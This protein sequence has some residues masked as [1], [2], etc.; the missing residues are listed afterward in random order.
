MV[1][2][3]VEKIY[4]KYKSNL[5]EIRHIEKTIFAESYDYQK[6][7]ALL[8]EKSYVLREIYE[9]N[10]KL[11][12]EELRELRKNEEKINGELVT[13][14]LQHIMYFVYEDHQD[15]ELTEK[16]LNWLEPY[17]ETKA[18]DWQKIKFYYIK[19]LMIAKGM[20]SHVQ[21]DWYEKITGVCGD[22]TK[23]DRNGSKERLLDSYLYRVMYIGAY[24][25]EKT[26]L[27]FESVDE[28]VRQWKRPETLSLLQ[29][30]YGKEK[31]VEHYINMRLELIEYMQYMIVTKEN[32]ACMSKEKLETLYE[33]F[34]KNYKIGVETRKL[35]CRIFITYHK[36]RYFM[37]ITDESEY[38]EALDMYRKPSP[39]E[40]PT[41]MNFEMYRADLFSC[42]ECNRYFCNSF[43]YALILSPEKLKY[44]KEQAKRDQIY[45]EIEQYVCGLSTMENGVYM[46]IQL[47]E[48]MK[49]LA[50]TM[51]EN[52]VF[53]L[54]ETIML[55]RQLPTAIHLAMVSKLVNIYIELILNEKPE[56]LIGLLGT[57]SVGEVQDKREEIISFAVKA[58]LC[59]DIGKLI[60]TDIINLQSRR[61]TDEEF[62]MIKW[63]PL[64]G[65]SIAEEI[66]AFAP[67]VDI[68][69]GHHLFADQTGGYPR[70]VDMSQSAD[71]VIINLITI[72]DSIDAAT[73]ILGR[74]YAKGK[75]FSKILAE[76]KEQSGTRYSKELVE[77][78][79]NSESLKIEMTSLTGEKRAGVYHDLYARRVKPLALDKK[80][81]ER[82]FRTCGAEDKESVVKFIN[83]H[84]KIDNE[85]CINKYDSCE[86]KYLVK[87]IEDDIIGVFFGKKDTLQG[88]D[89]VFIELLLVNEASRHAGIGRRLL[90][91][92]EEE[93]REKG[94]MYV[95]YNIHNELGNMERFMWIN[96]YKSGKDMI[97]K[98]QINNEGEK[99]GD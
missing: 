35:N 27:F 10:E 45:E 24:Q 31:D 52:K 47:V 17:I 72:C 77:V 48:I 90:F 65:K 95:A 38:V 70:E 76:L 99:K 59:H 34:E 63:H 68:I 49:I 57:T 55:H 60:S 91:Y 32:I 2:T 26:D 75:D 37:G 66:P 11:L 82:Y 6:W 43:S 41:D 5:Y 1:A 80:Y 71:K 16:V 92:V 18:Q 89:A 12:N 7:E 19:G 54:L 22:W 87:N 40:Y 9:Q 33:Y 58:G 78:L 29:E 20:S 25:R 15:F 56:L 94:Y 93:L 14:L 98:K 44:A 61:I 96:G 36:L 67:Y 81:V 88:K 4:N 97:L 28:A 30:I 23:A 85:L 84:E 8:R 3:D 69:V 46:D 53:R 64:A 62:G 21:Y 42:L 51:E 39:Y 74:N 79:D 86:E 83:A 73:D 13:N 50:G